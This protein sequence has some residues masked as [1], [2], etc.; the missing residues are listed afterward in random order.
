[1][2]KAAPSSRPS[3]LLVPWDRDF[4]DAVAERLLAATAGDFRQVTVLFPL[5]RAGRFLIDR[6][7]AHPGL[8][9][10]C[11]LPKIAAVDQ[12]LAELGRVIHGHPL[13][14]LD[15]LGRVGLLHAVVQ[16]L[17]KGLGDVP[18]TG[19]RVFP[20]E[21]H[22]FFPW[23][24]RLA[25]L[26]EE[27]FRHGVAPRN[28]DHAAADVLPQAAAILENLKAIH[29]A[30]RRRLL[31]GGTATPGLCQALAAEDPEA[32]SARLAGDRLF[33][34][35]FFAPSGSEEKIFR[36]LF[37][38]GRLEMLWHADPLLATDPA[39][40]HFS[41]RELTDLARRFAAPVVLHGQTLPSRPASGRR[42]RADDA[43][44]LPLFPAAAPLGA[45]EL[46][47]AK[48][49]RFY[50]GYDLHSQL[51]AFSRELAQ[52]PD[53]ADTA[54]VLPDTGLLM[55][56]LHH[57]PRRDVNISMGYP[58]ARSSISRLIETILRLQE[59]R[60][61]P[62]RYAWREVVAFLRHPY[63]KMLKTGET[64]PLRPLF[65][66]W[67]RL[68]RQGGAHLDP[69]ALPPPGAD[70]DT[71]DPDAATADLTAAKALAERVLA[72]C[73]GAFEDVKTP[74]ELGD[75][76]AGLAGLLLDEAHAG[77]IWERFLIDAECLFRVTSG[78]IPALR[79]GDLADEP[80]PARTLY[81]LLRGLL[82]AER[83]AFEAEP[84]SGLQVMGMLETRLLS[85]S[86]IYL[87]D[88]VEDRLPGVAPH[89][90]LLPDALRHLLGLSDSRQR[91]AVAAYTFYRLI[92]GASEVVIFYRA[93]VQSTGL[94]DDKPMRSRFVEQLLWGMEK[95]RGEVIKPGDPPLFTVS[96]PLRAIA[97][98]DAS[99][100]KTPAVR[101]ALDRVLEKPLSAS[102][103]DA[104][105][106]CPLRFY[107]GRV[108]R[109]APLD[110]VAE[111]G[112]AAGLGTLV[113]EVLRATFAPLVGREIDGTHIGLE[114][115]FSRL[116]AALA[117]APFFHALPPD[118]RLVLARTC[119]ERLRRY[120]A[121]M[122]RTTPLSLETRLSLS[123]P[124]A[125]REWLFTGIVDRADRRAPGIVILDYK[126][127]K[128]RKPGAALWEDEGFWGRLGDPA[129]CE[130]EGLLCEV[131]DRVQSVQLPL[132]A[133]LYAKAT[134]ETPV[135][136][137]CVE[138]RR[139]GEEC[140]L[141]GE[142]SPPEVRREAI[143]MRTPVLVDYLVRHIVAAP[144]FAP[145]PSRACDWCEFAGLCGGDGGGE[146]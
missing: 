21:L 110:E 58:L 112:D 129:A 26:C 116:D 73:L 98:Q 65:S 2:S 80:F 139:S 28:I 130:D 126:T 71:N 32:A 50:E 56:V 109:L 30:Y 138:L 101:A 84:L 115:L 5:R 99:V 10:P 31:A 114:P 120:V 9:K 132:Y 66:A 67:E 72:V 93:G 35:G 54:V 94:F 61:G 119:R 128:P 33:A 90:P 125:G 48:T 34:C 24:L 87:L 83:A 40:A 22:R 43:L 44:Q 102:F 108:L 104:Y 69:F 64:Q 121:G 131:R 140:G 134:G 47:A 135:E 39:R 91:D 41:C 18:W 82:S 78:V 127:G 38:A 4:I 70:A 59:T 20:T 79:G 16:D 145:T 1:M 146:T 19:E 15:P 95:R 63:L 23:G 25:E 97:P 81:T 8:D 89:D 142:K 57:L 118:G 46:L 62:G 36:T 60:L 77:D 107:Y 111:E 103:L 3:I 52:A 76:L 113:H 11:L 49:I 17:Q 136:A 133:H 12:W 51:V 96:L 37:T 53:T 14:L 141:F 88:A 13:R 105:L 86:R 100:E 122:P 42:K 29:A 68:V 137:A 124:G 6:L 123:L 143:L 55:P 45:D 106:I 92:M 74:R 85:F 27:L 117:A 75:A 7:A 144:R